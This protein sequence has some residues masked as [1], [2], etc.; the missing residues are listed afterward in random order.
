MAGRANPDTE[1]NPKHAPTRAAVAAAGVGRRQPWF[2][3]VSLFACAVCIAAERAGGLGGPA[4]AAFGLVLEPVR[5][6]PREDPWEVRLDLRLNG[7]E[8]VKVL[9]RFPV[10]EERRDADHLHEPVAV[11]QQG[12]Q[13]ALMGSLACVRR[14]ARVLIGCGHA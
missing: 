11:R 13:V 6:F 2:S 5:Q 12:Q 4:G 7:R 3:G 9:G 10:I 8:Q 14:R 1:V